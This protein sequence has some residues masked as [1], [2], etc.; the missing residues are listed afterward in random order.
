M[1][2]FEI[3]V[4]QDSRQGGEGD[5]VPLQNQGGLLKLCF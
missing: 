1:C 3:Y 5:F 4:N 2:L